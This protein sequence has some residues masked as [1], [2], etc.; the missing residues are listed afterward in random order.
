[1]RIPPFGEPILEQVCNVLGDTQ[2]GSL[3]AKL[4]DIFRN[5][6]LRTRIRE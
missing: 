3:V 1:M 5:A 4:V 2:T 6:V